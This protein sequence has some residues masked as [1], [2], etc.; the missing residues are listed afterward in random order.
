MRITIW[1]QFSSNHSASFTIV[2]RFES[3]S[4]AQDAARELR[5][6][7]SAIEDWHAQPENATISQGAIDPSPVEKQAAERYGVQWSDYSIDWISSPEDTVVVLDNHVVINSM[8][9]TWLGPK[10]FDEI[11]EKLG[12]VTMVGGESGE[13]S[14]HADIAF[15]A[16]DE[17]TATALYEA[18]RAYFVNPIQLRSPWQE[19]ITLLVPLRGGEAIEA[20]P[21]EQ[22]EAQD[23]YLRL[24][25]AAN[26]ARDKFAQSP[27]MR[28][29]FQASLEASRGGDFAQAQLLQ[30]KI[31]EKMRNLP[32]VQMLEQ[33]TNAH[34][35]R[36]AIALQSNVAGFEQG[37]LSG[38]VT[39]D[40]L[41][42]EIANLK[43]SDLNVGL[44]LVL[45]FL[46]TQGCH[47]IDYQ[48][49]LE[50]YDHHDEDDTE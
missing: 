34:P 42:L 40:G 48:L 22:I 13:G 10:P 32:E 21:E 30:A 43:L 16:P 37:A 39:R 25:N 8:K 11:M 49:S 19:R 5:D 9:E 50:E 26:E 17:A 4:A 18:L 2:G 31:M 15:K 35:Q 29:L 33:E 36:Y 41:R 12:G 24:T 20:S 3:D 6:I 23:W 46:K 44:P 47:G 1:E 7:M 28:R 38:A 14:I 27:E 45:V